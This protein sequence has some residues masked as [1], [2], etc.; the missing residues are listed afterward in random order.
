MNALS[1]ST[2]LPERKRLNLE[3]HDAARRCD[4]SACEDLLLEGADPNTHDNRGY[5]PLHV[6]CSTNNPEV[7][8]EV[9]IALAEMLLSAGAKFDA[10]DKS[11]FTPLMAAAHEGHTMLVQRLLKTKAKVNAFD[12]NRRTALNWAA[13][14][15]HVDVCALLLSAG[16]DI[17]FRD[18]HGACPMVRAAMGGETDVIRFLLSRGDS[19]HTSDHDGSTPLHWAAA[20]GELEAVQL[21]LSHGPH[22]TESNL[23]RETALHW[24]AENGHPGVFKALLA[25]GADIR[26]KDKST[27]TPLHTAVSST[28]FT[29]APDCFLDVCKQL[30]DAGADIDAK[31]ILGLTP[32]LT[33]AKLGRE[34]ACMFLLK[35]GADPSIKGNGLTVAGTAGRHG[36]PGLASQLKAFQSAKASSVA[37]DSLLARSAHRVPM[38]PGSSGSSS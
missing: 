32:L 6:V 27:N 28:K 31:N 21:I 12:Q 18:K 14:R 1:T 13:R 22:L 3:L 29:E 34:E 26:A 8:P 10:R 36:F 23:K 33:A 20:K 25:A 35:A 15:G 7:D 17:D 19:I 9:R 11:R 16:A 30:V 4:A 38:L 5:T 24:A 37:V 2:S